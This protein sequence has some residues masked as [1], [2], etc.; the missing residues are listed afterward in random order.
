M[1]GRN[2]WENVEKKLR[3]GEIW[4]ICHWQ[5]NKDQLPWKIIKNWGNTLEKIEL[6]KNIMVFTWNFQ[7]HQHTSTINRIL[8]KLMANNT[9][10]PSYQASL[11]FIFMKWYVN[12]Y[13]ERNNKSLR[14][15]EIL[16]KHA[17]PMRA[18]GLW[19]PQGKMF[20]Y[21]PKHQ[22]QAMSAL[23]R[24]QGKVQN[25]WHSSSKES[26]QWKESWYSNNC[27]WLSELPMPT[28]SLGVVN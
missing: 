22:F 21:S 20:R 11:V 9:R 7:Y 12:M 6:I 3:Y 10:S 23:D 26:K 27:A 19:M 17:K 14:G 15:Y 13:R 25:N 18:G 16:C 5:Y 1:L 2:D 8:V 24:K 28:S 4:K